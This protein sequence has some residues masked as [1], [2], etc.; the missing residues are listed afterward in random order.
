MN[1]EFLNK[2]VATVD[3]IDD[4]AEFADLVVSKIV[5][6]CHVIRDGFQTCK[7]SLICL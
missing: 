5:T 6:D 2:G 3:R 4:H 7:E 1:Y